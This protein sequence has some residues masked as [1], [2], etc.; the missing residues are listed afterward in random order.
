MIHLGTPG[1]IAAAAAACCVLL[2]AAA[3]GAQSPFALANIGGD[4]RSTDARVDGRG[5][6][7]LSE[8][9]TLSPCFHNIAGLTGLKKVSVVISGYGEQ[10]DSETGDYRRQTDRVRTPSLRA[11]LPVARGRLVLTAG[12]NSLRATQYEFSKSMEWLV[13]PDTLFG[14]RYFTRDGTQFQLPVGAS[15][16]V[17]GG[18]SVGATVNFVNGMIRDRSSNFFF[19]TSGP[20]D[21]AVYETT[22]EERKDEFSGTSTTLSA[23][24]EIGPRAGLGFSWT[25]AHDWDVDR[26]FT[27]SGVA[28]T[29]SDEATW[30]LPAAWSVGGHIFF[31]DRWRVGAEYEYEDFGE[32]SGNPEWEPDMTEAWRFGVG[33]EKTAATARRGGLGNLPLRLGYAQSR[34]PYLV[35]G[36][37]VVEHRFSIGTGVPF[38]RR[39]GHLDF[40]LTYGMRGDLDKN[41]AEDSFW[42]LTVSLAGLERWW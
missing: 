15:Y 34:W 37:E 27:L 6:W 24:W 7:G 33:L 9:D 36:E 17:G 31:A 30:S 1:R 29:A 40:A 2:L 14:Q 20:D 13:E 25:S 8:S 35:G 5:G 28:A 11:A 38:S 16:A 19:D 22:T 4:I 42:R 12:F 10:V 18:L 23:L 3:A 32:F 26:T 41:G 21:S 39:S